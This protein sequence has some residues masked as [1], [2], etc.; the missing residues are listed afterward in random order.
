M[1]TVTEAP[2]FFSVLPIIEAAASVLPSAAVT[3]GVA[4]CMTRARSVS[5]RELMTEMITE[6]SPD[7]AF[8]ISSKCPCSNR[9]QNAQ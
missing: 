1:R 8:M 6:P 9:A 5:P 3:T 4:P 2:G 7:I